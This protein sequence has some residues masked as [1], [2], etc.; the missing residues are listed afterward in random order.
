MGDESKG[1][2]NISIGDLAKSDEQPKS[3]FWER[4]VEILETRW[5]E[6]SQPHHRLAKAIISLYGLLNICQEAYLRYVDEPTDEN[7][8]AW[9]DALDSLIRTLGSLQITLEIFD[10]RGFTFL[11]N[12]QLIDARARDV[13]KRNRAAK[14]RRRGRLGL[15]DLGRF[16]EVNSA[17]SNQSLPSDSELHENVMGDFEAAIEHLGTFIRA[18]FTLEEI[19]GA[20]Q[21]AEM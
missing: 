1:D 14:V 2:I 17:V 21:L 7:D 8:E 20:Q 19:F 12:Y 10:H 4:L 15:D 11:S 5:S 13:W 6:N 9:G 18:N 16:I 3:E